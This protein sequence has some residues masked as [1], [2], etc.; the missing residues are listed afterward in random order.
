MPQDSRGYLSSTAPRGNTI[1]EDR[2]QVAR[3]PFTVVYKEVHVRSLDSS[4]N[5]VTEL[6]DLL[7]SHWLNPSNQEPTQDCTLSRHENITVD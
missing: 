1:S 5:N 2:K 7:T 3:F 6:L 4:Y